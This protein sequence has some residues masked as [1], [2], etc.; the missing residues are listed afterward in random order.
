MSHTFKRR[1]YEYDALFY[2]MYSFQQSKSCVQ[3]ASPQLCGAT[4]SG[5]GLFTTLIEGTIFT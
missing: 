4:K 1:K 5:K 3:Y 2:C